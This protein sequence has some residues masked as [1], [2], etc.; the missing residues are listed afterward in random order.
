[1]TQ[2]GFKKYT[3]KSLDIRQYRQDKIDECNEGS[4]TIVIRLNE[5]NDRIYVLYICIY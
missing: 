4:I 3:K 1:M 2:I 5:M